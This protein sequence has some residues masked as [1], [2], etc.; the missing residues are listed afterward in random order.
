MLSS[1]RALDRVTFGRFCRRAQFIVLLAALAFSYSMVQAGKDEASAIAQG[2]DTTP[3]SATLSAVYSGKVRDRV[4][5]GNTALGA[6]GQLDGTLTATLSAS[7]GRTVTGLQLQSDAPG[8][9]DTSSGTGSWVLGVAS[10]LDGALLNMAGTM[11]VNFPVADGGSFVVFAS[12]YAGIEFVPGR[13]LTLIATFSDGSTATAVTTVSAP[14]TLSAVYS[15]K[16][17]DRVGPG[18]TALG[19]DG[20]LDGTLT[21]TLSASGGRTVTGLQLQSDAPGAWDTSSG[22]GSW[23]LGVAST[24]DG[25]LLNAA[26][27]M[28][29]NFPGADGG[30]F[31]VFAS[32]YAGIEFVPGRRLTL[33]ATFSDGS[34]AT[35]VTTV[36]A[37]ATLSAVYSGKVRDRV[38]PGNTALGADGQLD[39]TLTATLSASG[40]RTVTGLQLQSDAPGAWDTSSGSGSW[41]L[42]VA[43]T[44]D[45][46]LL[47]AAGTMAVNFPGADGGSFVVFASDYA[48]IEFVPGR[49]LTL[50][51]TFS[52][53]STATAVTTVSAPA[54]TTPPTG[55]LSINNNAPYT[56]STAVTLT[57]SAADEVGVTAYYVSTS[58]TTPGAT[59]PGWTAVPST[60]NYLGSLGY[61]LGS[62]N[63]TKTLYAW[64]KDAAGNVSTTASASILLDQTP[65]TNGTLTASPGNAQVTLNWSGFAD[66]GSGLAASAPYKLVFSASGSPFVSCT[67]DAFAYSGSSTTFTHTG[68]MNGVTYYYRLCASDTAGNVSVGATASAMPQAVVSAMPTLV[69]FVPAV[70]NAKDVVVNSA[71]GVAYV[72]SAE[73]GL[74]VVNVTNPS[75]PVV[76][77][78][79]NP[80][81]YGAR[82]AVSGTLAA[83]GAGNNAGLHIVDLSVPTDPSTVGFI[84]GSIQSVALAGRYAY[85]LLLIPGNP[86]HTDLVVVDLIVPTSP[87]T[88]GR[89]TLAGGLDVALVGSLAYVATGIAGLQ[90]V[91]VSAPTAPQIIAT[92]D[93]PGNASGVSVANGYA[94][95]A[96][97]SSIIAIDVHTPS[98]PFIAGSLAMSAATALK[99]S[100]NRVYVIDGLQLKV[101]D[102]SNPTAPMLLGA[103]NNFGAQRVDGTG[104]LAFLASS[105][106]TP[107]LWI[108][109]VSVP[110]NPTVL[111]N[112]YGGSD[113]TG[114]AVTNSLAAVTGSSLGLKVVDF[115]NPAAPIPVGSLSGNMRG[116]AMA[117]QFA[118][119]LQLIPGNPA[120]TDLIVV[121]LGVPSAPTIV[122]RLTLGLVG[123]AI[124][125]VGSLAY[126]AAGTSGLQIVDIS[127]PTAPRLVGTADT[128]GTASG[129]AIGNGYAYVADT[130][131][132][133]VIDVHN[134]TS[135]FVVGS[136]STPATAVAAVG[137]RVY[138]IA[139]LQFQIVDAT[140][141][142]APVLLSAWN[143]FGATAVDAAGT[144]AFLA[145]PGTDHYDLKG[146]VYILDVSV[147]TQVTTLEQ[148][149][150]PGSVRSVVT[151]NG[152]VYAGDGAAILD[153]IDLVP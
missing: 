141:A 28:A 90:I 12:D 127:A 125:V 55:S 135:P 34:T 79:A 14:A 8:A 22:S 81:F 153:V 38:G 138:V 129:V 131:A 134:S 142:V 144:Q 9:W 32:D 91:D 96:D 140:S 83:V 87:A 48:G 150:V 117:G 37:P 124:K 100:G 103:S 82:V 39:G 58:A 72:A 41:V 10:T 97:G 111:A 54:G 13:R 60:L 119:V 31:V 108:E 1:G 6:D 102:I 146:G 73:F 112:L 7:G 132:L 29:V 75:Q 123:A 136:L 11:A 47:N 63:G 133:V 23:V 17:R 21:A 106:N 44:L 113:N 114:V 110:S 5:P 4:G 98:S 67:A 52:D 88:V 80:P 85:A 95:I 25:A 68:L 30:S 15:G 147:P 35:A 24:L 45:G 2:S 105:N 59:A 137:A 89:V 56:G 152:F 149:I 94:Y 74:S 86:A 92:L 66:S 50:I 18:N 121:D 109:N 120:H 64:Y 57:L 130:T 71:T 101:L 84:S 93:T 104:A 43:S 151:S 78:A 27:T 61:T 118:Y 40:G 20:Q 76:I 36:S 139:G 77:G 19:A 65:P 128:P 69:G 126:V 53:G 26:G 16:V 3:P 145:R 70:A 33:I 107:G 115:S 99:A 62:G 143:S 46:A 51:A 49:R 116:V 122:G 148:L 42:G